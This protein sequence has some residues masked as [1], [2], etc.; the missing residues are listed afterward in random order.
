MWKWVV[1]VLGVLGAPLCAG[2]PALTPPLGFNTWATFGCSVD[3]TILRATADRLH[4][5]GL[6]AAGYQ[7][8]NSDDCATTVARITRS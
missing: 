5:L 8:V 1:G 3:D 4:A 2:A 6:Q 7:T